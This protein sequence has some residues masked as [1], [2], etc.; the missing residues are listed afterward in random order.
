MTG[1]PTPPRPSI[2][3][4]EVRGGNGARRAVTSSPAARRRLPAARSP[5]PRPPLSRPRH[6]LAATVAAEHPSPR[7]FPLPPHS[8]ATVPGRR[9]R[10]GGWSASSRRPPA[11]PPPAVGGGGV[12]GRW[13]GSA[14]RGGARA[15]V[16]GGRDVCFWLCSYCCYPP[17]RGS[18][19]PPP[20][21]P[22][23]KKRMGERRKNATNR[24]L[25]AGGANRAAG[26]ASV[27]P[28]GWAI[29]ASIAADA[30]GEVGEGV[31]GGLRGGAGVRGGRSRALRG[32]TGCEGGVG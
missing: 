15:G 11:A 4:V 17:C 28:V 29:S 31:E 12:G 21:L 3:S 8:P 5:S 19:P 10:G 1:R 6:L 24:A 2:A 32:V 27:S 16:E 26:S 30:S 20:L 13:R 14:G 9:C 25:T 22:K 7:P 18:G 23:K